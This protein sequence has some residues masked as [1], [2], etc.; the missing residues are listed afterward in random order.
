MPA[1]QYAEVDR[2][3]QVAR[4]RKL[5]RE[6]TDAE[7]R[8]WQ[9]LRCRQLEGAKFRRQHWIGQYVLDFYCPDRRLAVEA[10]GGQHFTTEGSF[11]DDMRTRY[12]ENIGIRVLRFTNAQVMLETESVAEAIRLALTGEPSP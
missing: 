9:I 11:G 3:H 1:K 4:C 8:L 12:L 7:H 10:D 5:R 2:V 6:S